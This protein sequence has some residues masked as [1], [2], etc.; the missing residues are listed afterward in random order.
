MKESNETVPQQ[1]EKRKKAEV[2]YCHR[3]KKDIRQGIVVGRIA[4]CHVG[5]VPGADGMEAINSDRG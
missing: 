5:R 3:P 4:A 1:F 2:N